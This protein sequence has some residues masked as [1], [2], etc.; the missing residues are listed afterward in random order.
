MCA[1][2]THLTS[3]TSGSSPREPLGIPHRHQ[4]LLQ[5]VQ[6]R[7][8]GPVPSK[9]MRSSVTSSSSMASAALPPSCARPTM[10]PVSPPT[11]RSSDTRPASS[12]QPAPNSGM[13]ST[14]SSRSGRG[15]STI[16]RTTSATTSPG[17]TPPT[18]RNS[19]KRAPLSW[20]RAD[21]LSG[22]STRSLPSCRAV[23]LPHPVRCDHAA[24]SLRHL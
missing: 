24:L 20:R 8:V 1:P 18:A 12:P 19:T 22:S 11:H 4:G 21:P 16:Y 2:T 15:P 23:R 6:G 7:P 3:R 17:S 9:E 10:S 13:S 5:D 14:S